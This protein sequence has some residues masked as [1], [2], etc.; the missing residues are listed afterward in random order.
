MMKEYTVF[1]VAQ[2]DGLPAN[3]V[4]GKAS[5]VRNPDT[6]DTRPMSSYPQAGQSSAKDK[7]KRTTPLV[8]TS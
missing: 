5:R 7:A 1:N 6:R 4:E 3:I 2:C 8:Q